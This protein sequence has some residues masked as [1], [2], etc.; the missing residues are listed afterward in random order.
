MRKILGRALISCFIIL[1]SLGAQAD[2]LHERILLTFIPNIQFAPFYVGIADGH[3][4]RQGFEVTLEHL[5]EPDV[6]DLVAAGQA[7]FGIVSGEQV[8]LARAKS[9]DVVY[10]YEW[11]QD[12]PVGIVMV[13]DDGGADLENLTDMTVGIPGRFGASYSGLTT[14][15][16][17]AGLREDD[18][19]LKEIGFNA[20]DVFCLGA[21]DAA[22]VYVNNEPLQIRE[23][24]AAGDCG[25][26]REITVVSVASRV[27]LVSNGL[28]VS[29]DLA[30]RDPDKVQ[31]I[32]SG[33]DSA[34]KATI[35]NPANAYLASLN[36]V[37]TLP[38]EPDFLMLLR[39]LAAEQ[40]AFLATD[41]SRE[42]IAE[43]RSDMVELLVESLGSDDLT[44]FEVLLRT[45]ELWDADTLGHSDLS[46]WEAMSDTLRLMGLLSDAPPD[47]SASFSNQFVTGIRE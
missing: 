26:V 28:I 19:E 39:E 21:V 40:A 34:L 8:I 41:P 20:P 23:R 13:S 35:N 38:G 17:S 4:A 11:F 18:I 45:I 33:F 37:E 43:S 2:L 42:Q 15:L 22:V 1:S 36:F 10:V 32:A 44:Q 31:G 24:L 16:Q 29:A 9:R 30:G 14:L 12:Y 6:L 3:F 47:L 46:S 27:D 25:D 5:Q 7:D